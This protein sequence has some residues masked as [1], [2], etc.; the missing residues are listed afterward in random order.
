MTLDTLDI[1]AGYLAAGTALAAGMLLGLALA[2][3]YQ[4]VGAMRRRD[5]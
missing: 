1:L 5:K 3:W 2:M 4:A